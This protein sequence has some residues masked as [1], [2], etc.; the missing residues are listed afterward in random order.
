LT[1]ATKVGVDEAGQP[2]RLE[3]ALTSSPAPRAF[4]VFGRALH[5]S[6]SGTAAFRDFFSF[7]A[8]ERSRS[9]C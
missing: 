2:S 4:V 5:L 6:T 9:T 7:V 3:D 1:K 8:E